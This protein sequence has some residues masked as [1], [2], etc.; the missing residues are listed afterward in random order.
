MYYPVLLL[1]EKKKRKSKLSRSKATPCVLLLK[2][3][4]SETSQFGFKFH[5]TLKKHAQIS[6][7]FHKQTDAT[8]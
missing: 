3:E 2:G 7:L 8:R 5:F 4:I 1:I 6:C